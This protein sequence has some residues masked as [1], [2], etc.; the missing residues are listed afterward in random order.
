MK[1]TEFKNGL[2]DGK[3]FS[4]Y[5]FE[6]ED[7]FFRERGLSLLKNKFVSE[8]ALNYVVLDEDVSLDVL[9]SSLEGFPF[10]SE[11]RLTCVREFYPKQEMFKKGLSAYLDNP[12]E[13]SI[14]AV[15]NEKSCEALKKYS[16]VQ[17]V[18]CS[19]ADYSLLVRW[20]KAQCDKQDVKIDAETAKTLCDYC[21]CDMTRIETEVNKLCSYVLDEKVITQTQ[22][23]ELISKDTEYKIYQMTDYIATRKFDLA[24][25][26]ITEMMG[27]GEASQVILVS[28]YNYFRKLLHAAITG[29]TEKELALELG[30]KEFAA[31]KIK[32][33]ASSFKKRSLKVAVDTLVDTDYKIKSGQAEADE[34]MWLTIFKIMTDN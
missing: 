34:R 23:D 16:C 3:A 33:Q 8:P 32:Q 17:V 6:G 30:V 1:Y 10:L 31:K 12:S 9:L 21:L 7:A 20:V 2:E 18:D 24:L 4:V 27:K 29:L 25:S 28:I 14:F 15:L 26:V 5:L 13:H 19:K 22:I 11:K